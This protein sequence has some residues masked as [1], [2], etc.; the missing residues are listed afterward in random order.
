MWKPLRAF[1]EHADATNDIFHVAAQPAL[2]MVLLRAQQLLGA[3]SGKAQSGGPP[4]CQLSSFRRYWRSALLMPCWGTA[5]AGQLPSG[6]LD[7]K[8]LSTEAPRERAL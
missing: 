8:P 7:F 2:A 3:D 4:P 6:G 5:S 1:A